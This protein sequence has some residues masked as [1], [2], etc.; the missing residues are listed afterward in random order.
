[1]FDLH[2]S[3]ENFP[4]P[5]PRQ[6]LG[7]VCFSKDCAF[8]QYNQTKSLPGLSPFRQITSASKSKRGSKLMWSPENP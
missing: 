5:P 2:F 6:T 7:A 1:M 3:V 4:P 8:A